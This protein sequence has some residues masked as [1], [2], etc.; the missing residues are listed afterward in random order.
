MYAYIMPATLKKIITN[1][2]VLILLLAGIFVNGII[3]SLVIPLWQNN[4]ELEHLAYTAFLVEEKKMPITVASAPST[5]TDLTL[6]DELRIADELLQN[7]QISQAASAHKLLIHQTF[8]KA[9]TQKQIGAALGSLDRHIPAGRYTNPTAGYP[10][11]YYALEAIPYGI[12]YHASILTR[13]EA[14]RIFNILFLL[15]TVFFTYKT[16]LLVF[17]NK[18]AALTVAALVGFLPRFSFTSAGLDNDQLL[19]SLST[20]LIYLL[21]KYLPEKLTIKKSL[22]LGLV[23]GLGLLSKQ[24]FIVFILLLAIFFLIKFFREK[25][26]AALTY[27]MAIIAILALAISGWWYF[28][29]YPT[30]SGSSLITGAISHPVNAHLIGTGLLIKA[31]VLRYFYLFLT[32]FSS[33]GCCHEFSLAPFYQALFAMSAG[34]GFFGLLFFCLDLKRYD[35]SQK[36]SFFMLVLAMLMLE[37]AYLYIFCKQL[38]ATGVIPGFPIDG[39][40]LYPVIAPLTI[41]FV[42]GLQKLLPERLHRFL[43]IFLIFGIII[44]NGLSLLNYVMPRYYL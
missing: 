44:I 22:L 41:L 20:I 24:Q 6:S 26:F 25:K 28:G 19:I 39:R 13:S 38:L 10:P 31:V 16:T 32:Y 21:L 29:H 27:S 8:N 23:F 9:L 2:L 42:F 18:T 14:M 4:D 33:F 12:F 3:Y 7:N 30:G 35:K 43:Y 15:V 34:L 37:G 11:L 1:N 40:Y 17:K 5:D 36:T